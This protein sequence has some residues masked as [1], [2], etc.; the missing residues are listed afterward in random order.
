MCDCFR[1]HGTL[2]R[3]LP[4]LLPIFDRLLGEARFGIVMRQSFELFGQASGMYRLD[5]LRDGPVELT[6][7][8]M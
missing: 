5:G 3:A 2:D 6:T 4:G 7:P 1:V 8:L